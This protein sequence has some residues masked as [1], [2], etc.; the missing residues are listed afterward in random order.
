MRRRLRIQ[1]A[2]LAF[3]AVNGLIML[4]IG[5]AT[6]Y[7]FV[8]LLGL[9]ISAPEVSFTT[10][11]LIPPRLS[12]ASYQKVLANEF[13]A[14]GFKNTIVRTVLGVAINVVLAVFAAYPLSKRYFPLRR[15]WTA[16]IV[17][18]MFF[19]G[20]LIPSYLL[21]KSLGLFNTV[22]ALILPTAIGTFTMIIVRNFFMALPESLEESAR[23][24]G[25][26]EVVVLFWIV[27]PMSKPIIATA[28]LWFAVGHWNSWF[29]SLIYIIDFRKQVLQVVLRRIVLEGTQQAMEVMSTLYDRVPEN[30]ESIKAATIMVATI[31]I[32]LVYPFLQKY[33]VK[34]VIIGALKG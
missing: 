8:Y 4:L 7:P 13:I 12:L 18:T 22:W 3:R 30:P 34:G 31:P 21:V 23:I 11:Y 17:F 16:F 9:S 25:A 20:G 5:L 27:L 26:N 10:V 28:S 33:F 29:E 14:L 19:E 32:I 15:F 1:P 2:D 24:D 6:V